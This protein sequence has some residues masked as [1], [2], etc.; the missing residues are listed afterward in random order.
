MTTENLSLLIPDFS[1]IILAFLV[2]L[3]DLFSPKRND[4]MLGI[5][6]VGG[7]ILVSLYIV[8]IGFNNTGYLYQNTLVVDQYST[9]LKLFFVFLGIVAIFSSKNYLSLNLKN[10]GEFYSIILFTISGIMLLLS[11]N[12]LLTGFICLELISFGLYVLVGFNRFNPKSNES[13]LKYILLG[14][15]SS[16]IL[17]YGISYIYGFIGSTK[18]DAIQSF[19][20]NTEQEF[21]INHAIGLG[22][23]IVGFAFKIAAVPFHMW[24]PDTYEGAPLPI[25]AYISIVSK[26]AIFSFVIRIVISTGLPSVEFW[27]P[28][29]ISISIM[30]ML[31]GNLMA[32][33]QKDLKR[34]FAYSSIGQT[35]Y[36]LAGVSLIYT[37]D[38]LSGFVLS[39]VVFHMVSYAVSSYTAFYSLIII[40][41]NIKSTKIADFAGISSN[42]PLFAMIFTCSMF[43]LAGLPI[44]SGFISKFYLFSSF[45]QQ[46]FIWL[47]ALAVITSLISLYYY[48]L[49][50]RKIYTPNT[51]NTDQHFYVSRS[52]FGMLCILFLFVILLGIFPSFIVDFFQSTQFAPGHIL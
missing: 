44:F 52:S 16:A 48:L 51:K 23:L 7:L 19:L 14:A 3:A 39:A 37:V 41:N 25:T 15:L 20:T 24:A 4:L 31:L 29:I 26:L 13:S 12:D 43:S 30:S 5:L 17:I 38:G 8:T 2:L 18:F 46:G 11:S 50:I 34:L 22:L 9:S 40:N 6:S 28:I 45:A 35:G 42:S 1:V 33:V 32:T 36:L 27:H 21:N 10:P 47:A 49:V